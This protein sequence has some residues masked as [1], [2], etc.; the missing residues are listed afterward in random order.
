MSD[1]EL[2]E[3]A[4]QLVVSSASVCLSAN[5]AETIRERTAIALVEAILEGNR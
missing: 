5:D 4:S 2:V 3:E 1:E